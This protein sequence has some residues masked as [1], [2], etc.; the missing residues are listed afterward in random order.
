MEATFSDFY[1]VFIQIALAL[2]VGIG[3]IAASHIFG[4]RSKTNHEKDTPYECGL[5]PIGKQHPRFG[6]KFYVVAMLFV[7]FDIEAVFILPLVFVYR[8]FVV[9]HPS[10]LIPVFFFIA[11]LA[12]GIL[13][14]IKKGALDW[15]IPKTNK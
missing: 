1:P 11:L 13:Y 12:A 14:E 4:Q 9:Q 5:V 7:I 8:D 6:V 15:N 10:V 2:A 3:I